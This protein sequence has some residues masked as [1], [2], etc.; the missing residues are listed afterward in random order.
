MFIMKSYSFFFVLYTKI[1]NF[2]SF[3][4]PYRVGFF[5]ELSPFFDI[6]RV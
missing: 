1:S 3:I 2:L 4:M 5:F 6:E